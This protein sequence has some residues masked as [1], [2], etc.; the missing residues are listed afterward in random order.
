MQASLAANSSVT[1]TGNGDAIAVVAGDTL[2]VNGDSVSGSSAIGLPRTTLEAAAEATLIIPISLSAA[3]A[4]EHLY[5]VP[6]V[7]IHH[8]FDNLLGVAAKAAPL[9]RGAWTFSDFLSLE[10][11]HILLRLADRRPLGMTGGP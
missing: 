9:R 10:K 7:S 3:L 6:A 4:L 8:H 1:V 5:A 2:T 11:L